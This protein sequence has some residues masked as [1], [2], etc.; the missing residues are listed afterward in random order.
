MSKPQK[1]WEVYRN[2]GEQRLFRALAR[3]EFKW[4]SVTALAKEAKLTPKETE[5]ILVSYQGQGIVVQNPKNPDNWGY[6]EIVGDATTVGKSLHEAD[7][8]ERLTKAAP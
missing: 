4:R 5:Q 7:A 3:S 2:D 8:D 1:W 6:W